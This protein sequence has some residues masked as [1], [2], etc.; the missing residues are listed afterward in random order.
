M[1]EQEGEM[2]GDVTTL[3]YRTHTHT[4]THTHVYDY[5]ANTLTNAPRLIARRCLKSLALVSLSLSLSF[6]EEGRISSNRT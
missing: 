3:N 2:Q 6:W 5:K 1:R 4:H